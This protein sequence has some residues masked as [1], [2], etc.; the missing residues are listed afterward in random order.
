MT[1]KTESISTKEYPNFFL[2][3]LEND[4]MKVTLTNYGCTVISIE[5]PD[6]NGKCENITAGFSDPFRIWVHILILDVL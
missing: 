1:I 5:V 6:R 4:A 3:H 2:F